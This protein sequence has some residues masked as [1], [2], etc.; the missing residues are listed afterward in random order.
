[1]YAGHCCGQGCPAKAAGALVEGT[2]LPFLPFVMCFSQS[3]LHFNLTYSIMESSFDH[4]G[5]GKLLD[6]SLDGSSAG[7]GSRPLA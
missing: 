6:D 2:S 3:P 5:E 4:E 7:G 1:M